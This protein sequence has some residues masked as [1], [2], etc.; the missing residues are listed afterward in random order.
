[1][2]RDFVAQSRKEPNRSTEI[3]RDK[4]VLGERRIPQRSRRLE[5]CSNHRR[6]LRLSVAV[7]PVV[8]VDLLFVI[9]MQIKN[10][11]Q[12]PAICRTRRRHAIEIDIKENLGAIHRVRRRVALQIHN[13]REPRHGRSEH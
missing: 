9:E 3:S 10:V 12:T 2:R 7:D 8:T 4:A 6:S 11:E 13:P 5:S 1:M